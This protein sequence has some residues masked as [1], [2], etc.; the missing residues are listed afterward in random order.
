Q[1]ASTVSAIDSL[2]RARLLPRTRLGDPGACSAEAKSLQ[3]SCCCRITHADRARAHRSVAG[4]E[5]AG[6]DFF[7][8]VDDLA[9]GAGAFG[10]AAA[11]AARVMRFAR[12]RHNRAGVDDGLHLCLIAAAAS[13]SSSRRFSVSRL[14]YN[15]LPRTTAIS[16]FTFPPLK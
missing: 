3:H 14:S 5:R 1:T 16:A 11:R 2:R 12:H 9:C 4:R 10:V 6:V 15:F 7:D 8:A 13:R